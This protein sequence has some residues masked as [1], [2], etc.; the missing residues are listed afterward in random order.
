MGKQIS[1][2]LPTKIQLFQLTLPPKKSDR[3]K[4]KK[5]IV[6]V[7][8]IHSSNLKLIFHSFSFLL[9]SWVQGHSEVISYGDSELKLA[10]C[11][12]L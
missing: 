6:I 11:T 2:K 10:D 4:N 1:Y 9:L 12:D 8:Q 3:E 7:K 5:H